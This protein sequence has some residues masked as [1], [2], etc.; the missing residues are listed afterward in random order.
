MAQKLLTKELL[1]KFKKI[2]RQ[3]AS[4]CGEYT[5]VVKFFCPWNDWTWY[6]T[7]FYEDEKVFYG[8]AVN[9]LG[10]EWGYTSLREMEDIRGPMGLKI[11]R[12]IS[13]K[14]KIR[15]IL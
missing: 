10:R 14:G 1:E 2:G 6:F 5:I 9:S 15:D 7:E 11:E 3:E 13:F 12:D 8:V 4:E